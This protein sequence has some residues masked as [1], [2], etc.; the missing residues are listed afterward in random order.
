MELPR[1]VAA[2]AHAAGVRGPVLLVVP[3]AL[4]EPV[5]SAALRGSPTTARAVLHDL[6]RPDRIPGL[7]GSAPITGLDSLLRGNHDGHRLS[8]RDRRGRRHR[9]D[10]SRGRPRTGRGWH[11]PFRLRLLA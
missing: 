2:R 7:L 10:V 8:A 11:L 9:A 1:R 3:P 5:E 4:V 6:V